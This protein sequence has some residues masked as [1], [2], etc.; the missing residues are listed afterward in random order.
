[1]GSE[2]GFAYSLRETATPRSNMQTSEL[3]T[4]TIA[5]A[6]A[7]IERR[8][9]SPVDLTRAYLERIERLNPLLNAYVTVTADQALAEARAAE[10][11]IGRGGYRGPLHGVPIALK[12]L[13][14]TRGVRTAAGSKI[15]GEWVPDVDSTVTV[16]LRQAGAVLLG[17]T[18]THEFAYGATTV[19]PHF[20]PSRN[21]WNID[22]ITGGSSGGS[23]AAVAADIAAMAMGTDT[24]GSIRCPAALCG[25]VGL[26]PTHGRV[27]TAGI[28]PLSWSL[29][30]P[31]PL[32]HTVEDAAIVLDAIAGFDPL[33][34]MTAPV[35]VQDYRAAVNG[36]IQGLRLGVPRQG[37]FDAMDSEVAAIIEAALE[38]F[39][40]LGAS[41]ED[42][43][44]PALW[45]GRAA[46]GDIIMAEARYYHADWLR[47]RPGDY[48][49]DVLARLNRRTDLTAAELVAAF[50]LRD[51]AIR[52]TSASLER[53]AA[54]VTPTVRVPAPPLADGRIEV[55]GQAEIPGT[56]SPSGPDETGSIAASRVLLTNTGPFNLT[57]MP[58]LSLPCGFTSDG[59]PIG[60]QIAGPR[61]D[62][63]MVIR[64]GAAYERA[65]PW[66]A[67]RPGRDEVDFALSNE[68]QR[69]RWPQ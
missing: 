22:H 63:A 35:P 57:G 3:T 50:R 44:A 62:E 47:V 23:G 60:L 25:T 14:A 15:L 55:P 16:R 56:P 32:T 39:R 18:N 17:K 67:R 59:L 53:Y 26:K 19:N 4:L 10:D 43:E 66:H 28:V 9:L 24:G 40:G 64:I 38:A 6:A 58:A 37:F 52:E 69:Q 46:V 21:P 12:D 20:G 48:G 29:D 45:N 8:G 11:E 7:Q 5:E 30:H 65:T 41:V 36:G 49:A 54:L 13:Y 2:P 33:D 1:M 31:G 27:S 61:W 34:T 42:I 51:A 68:N